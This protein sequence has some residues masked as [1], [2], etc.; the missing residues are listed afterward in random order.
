[1]VAPSAQEL[2][3][4][5]K[6]ILGVLIRDARTNAG[7]SPADC[8][9]LLGI[10]EEEYA[11]F[12]AGDHTPTLPQLEILAYVFNVPLKHFFGT[13]T[14]AQTQQDRNI[15]DRVAELTMLRQKVIGLKIR[16]L[17][18][19]AGLSTAQLA[20]KCGLSPG[21]VEVVERGLLPLPLTV[22]ESLARAANGRIED[23]M[24]G[25]GTVGSWIQAQEQFDAFVQL[26]PDLRAF[27]VRPINRSYLELAVRL[28]EMEVNRLRLI[29]ESILEITY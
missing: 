17:R 12:E 24:D 25:H 20:E 9:D 14:L 29:A 22:M 13:Q 26:P 18:E 19:Q 23:L 28:S 7:M 16:Q 27:V 5:R 6:R 8:S 3:T 1:M 10:P 11:R 4:V 21:Q 2:L 15:K